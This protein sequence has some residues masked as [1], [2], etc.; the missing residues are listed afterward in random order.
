MLTIPQIPRPPEQQPHPAPTAG[1]PRQR[2]AQLYA[3][4][5]KLVAWFASRLLTRPE[6]VEDVVQEVFVIAASNLRDLTEPPKIRGW[7][8][9]VTLRR[10]GR[11]LRWARLR[12]RLGIGPAPSDAVELV[13]ATHASPEDRAVLRQLFQVLGELPVEQRIAWTLRHMH[14]EPLETVAE[15]AGCSLATAKRRIA[16]AQQRLQRELGDD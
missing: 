8:K 14:E 10:V 16:A 3:D 12:A 4:Y 6:E 5:A 13:A 1:D 11:R 9:T 7:L 15:L 2:L